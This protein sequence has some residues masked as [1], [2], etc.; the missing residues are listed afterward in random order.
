MHGQT[1]SVMR[2]HTCMHINTAHRQANYY[3]RDVNL[4]SITF[5]HNN[6]SFLHVTINFT[7]FLW[8][9]FQLFL[10]DWQ[11][12][13]GTL[14]CHRYNFAFVNKNI[15]YLWPEVRFPTPYSPRQEPQCHHCP[16][17]LTYPRRASY[18]SWQ[19]TSVKS[20]C[21]ITSPCKRILRSHGFICE[22]TQKHHLRES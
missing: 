20:F 2:G 7:V 3:N 9:S 18:H 4:Y 17:S 5:Y 12:L 21:S 14:S 11:P 8:F 10:L 16:T 19:L 1:C 15:I 13:D 6:Y 22:V